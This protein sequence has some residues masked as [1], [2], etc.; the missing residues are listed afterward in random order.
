MVASIFSR[1]RSVLHTYLFRLFF[2]WKRSKRSSSV[3]HAKSR[4]CAEIGPPIAA[5]LTWTKN[6]V[7]I[8]NTRNVSSKRVA[9]RILEVHNAVRSQKMFF[10]RPP[11][12]VMLFYSGGQ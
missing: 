11:E 3:E 5:P 10:M 7:P 9:C 12:K 8:M 4:N 6:R 2:M 1:G